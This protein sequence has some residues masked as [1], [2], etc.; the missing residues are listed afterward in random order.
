MV[1]ADD[2]YISS[3]GNDNTTGFRYINTGYTVTPHTRVE[4]DYALAD[5]YPSGS[6]EDNHDWYLFAAY[7]GDTNTKR[8]AAYLNKG[9]MGWC[10]CGV[11]WKTLGGVPAAKTGKDI[12]RT[13]T[14]D[15]HT[16]W[17]GLTTAGFT[18]VAVSVAA[19]DESL[20]YDTYTL[21]L[22][23]GDQGT[24]G[25]AALKIYG[26]RIYENGALKHN[27]VPYVQ[28]GAAGLRD[29]ETGTFIMSAAKRPSFV[30]GGNIA[31]EG[32][33]DAYL[34]SDGTQGIN[35]G[36]LMKGAISRVE[37]D[38]AY[39]STYYSSGT[40][41]QQR[42]FGQDSVT[43]NGTDLLAAFYIT[44]GGTFNFGFGNT[45]INNH[46]PMEAANTKRHTAVI[47][48]Y[49][50]RLYYIT[51]SVTN[52]SYDISGDAHG[53][54]S[55]WPMGIFAT[56]NNQAA[57]TWRNGSIMKL[58][59]FRIYEKDKLT[60]EYLPYKKGDV[61]GLY[62]TVDNVVLQDARNSATPFK[63]GG[64]GVDGVER[65]IVEP[66][67]CALSKDSSTVT[68]T[69]NAA[70]AVSYKWTRNGESVEGGENGELAIAWARRNASNMVD[71]YAVTPV[72]D[73]FGV[74]TDG[75]PKTCEVT[76]MP[77]GALLILR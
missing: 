3:S 11:R 76:N 43:Q 6:Y 26:C 33:D 44:S 18:N 51:G 21:K 75:A 34:E 25:F 54:T 1:E 14:V 4:L 29:T 9:G 35:L 71:T 32:K 63:I 52:N 41:Y 31:T 69:A 60:H 70:G 47:D 73:V 77:Q 23:S 67:G 38:F 68:L 49:H 28:D 12:R 36:Y 27:Y 15:N 56:P 16:G 74:A 55:T 30:A 2:G 50:N 59:S 45:F 22:S 62:D 10:G 37:A 48:G 7:G 53:N 46:G 65:W 24:T 58:Y 13:M 5:N 19:A 39:V 42:A 66:K 57:T 64:K 20:T 61:V 72:Y 8:F 17:I 40:T